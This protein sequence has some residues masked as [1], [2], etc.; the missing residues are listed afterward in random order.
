MPLF[1]TS[2]AYQRIL[3]ALPQ[4][5]VFSSER[6]VVGNFEL[7]LLF[8]YSFFLSSKPPSV[9]THC[10]PCIRVKLLAVKCRSGNIWYLFW[11][12]G[13]HILSVESACSPCEESANRKGT[14][15][16]QF[17]LS[18]RYLKGSCLKAV[19]CLLSCLVLPSNLLTFGWRCDSVF[20][21]R[22]SFHCFCSHIKQKDTY[23]YYIYT[24]S[25]CS[26]P[27]ENQK[28]HARWWGK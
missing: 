13:S 8:F 28:N 27:I 10:Y 20:Q 17:M 22:E 18:G 14:T 2:E 26:K 6:V 12:H 3:R 11:A 25:C 16:C 4:S 24:L 1:L 7:K 21:K 5:S 19:L 23:L 15:L 9:L